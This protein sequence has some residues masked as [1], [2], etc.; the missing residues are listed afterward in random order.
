MGK[1]I[2]IPFCTLLVAT[3]YPPKKEKQHGKQSFSE[4]LIKLKG[5]QQQNKQLH[6]HFF[7]SYLNIKV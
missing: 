2:Y 3:P 5:E 7:L 1:G 4:Y 6:L